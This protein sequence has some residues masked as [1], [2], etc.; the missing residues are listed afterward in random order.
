MVNSGE[1]L[2]YKIGDKLKEKSDFENCLA[3][4]NFEIGL[5]FLLS[6]LGSLALIISIIHCVRTKGFGALVGGCSIDPSTS[7]SSSL[8]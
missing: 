8:S 6:M 4:K 5:T 3:E 7:R 1:E 2:F